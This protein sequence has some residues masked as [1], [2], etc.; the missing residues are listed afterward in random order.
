M[1]GLVAIE[2]R[3]YREVIGSAI[4]HLRPHIEVLIVEPEELEEKVARLDPEVVICST[5]NTRIG[6]TKHS[7]VELRPYEEIPSRLSGGS[8][9]WQLHCLKS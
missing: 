7:W 8:K 2:P 9:N 1:R 4:Q 3:S 6:S 5:P